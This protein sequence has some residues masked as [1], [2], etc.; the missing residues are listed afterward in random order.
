MVNSRPDGPRPIGLASWLGGGSALVVL[1]AVLAMAVACAVLLERLVERQALARAELAAATARDLLRRVGDETLTDARVLAE[2]PTLA[3]LLAT[4]GTPAGGI[5]FFLRSYCESSRNDACALIGPSGL[6]ARAGLAVSWDE[7]LT[8]ATEQGER[9]LV[10]PASGGPPLWGAVASLPPPAPYRVLVLREAGSR[11]LQEL[12]TRTGAN[13]SVVN[14]RTYTAPPDDEW[15]PLQS[16]ALADGRGA[17]AAL[18]ASGAIAATAV[19]AAA[20]GE[21]IALLNARMDGAELAGAVRNF[22]RLLAVAAAIVALAAGAA[23]LLYG[24]WLAR[25]VVALRDMAARIGRGDF[26]AAVPSVAPHEVGELA[27]SMD[28]MRRNLVDLT[29]TLRHREAEVQAVLDG[30]VEG[31]YTVDESRI[32]RYV[33][34]Q[35]PQLLGRP[36]AEIVGRFCGDVLAPRPVEGRRPCDHACPILA[37]RS[38]GVGRAAESVALPDGRAR[39]V[40]IVSAAPVAGKQ[41]QVL[42]DETDIEAARRARDGVLGHVSHEFRTPLAAQLASIELLR[43]GLDTLPRSAQRDLLA[44]AERGGLR[45]MRLIDNLLESVRIEAGQLS[46]RRQPVDLHEVVHEAIEL[47]QPLIDQGGLVIV[48]ELPADLPRVE[49]DAQRLGQVFVNLL[50]NA[51]KFSPAGGTIRV[52]GARA[53][54]HA[55]V[56]IEDEGEGVP[57]GD[58]AAIF[59]RFRRTEAEAEPD[60][61]GLGLGLWIARSIVERHGGRIGVERT[62]QARTRFRFTLPYE[63]TA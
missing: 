31:V 24:R 58:A 4:D 28:E 56:W 48:N 23:G 46:I 62:A 30:I 36:E 34:A 5:E 27:R 63:A 14:F 10:A 54:S 55:E 22:N 19:V 11:L 44:N 39:P 3:R 50:S 32:V 41:V 40:T 17:S 38:A 29:D 20:S 1:A 61:P 51:I 6:V 21:V 16:R 37:A 45:L 15:T 2:R 53:P 60:A 59:E 43:D 47:V 12:G 9:F 26:T 57:D 13:L 8:A 35:V 42:R 49:G 18:P 7:A 52:G 25:P 33:N